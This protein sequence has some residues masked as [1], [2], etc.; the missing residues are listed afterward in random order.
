MSRPELALIAAMDRNRVIGRKQTLPWKLPADLKRFKALTMGHPILMGRKTRESIGRS[1]PGRRNLVLT[2]QADFLAE[3]A[4]VVHSIEEALARCADAD[5]LFVIGGE[6]VYADC[7]PLADR[8][9]LT[10]VET[11]VEEGDAWFPEWDFSRFTVENEIVVPADGKN[12][13]PC[14]IVDYVKKA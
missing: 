6:S 5:K 2:R 3:D 14:R 11:E 1:L 10:F 7:L 9:Y 12:Q 8:L 4:E 13:Y